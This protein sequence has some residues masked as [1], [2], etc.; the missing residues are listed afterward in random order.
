MVTR[1]KEGSKIRCFVVLRPTIAPKYDVTRLHVTHSLSSSSHWTRI[2]KSGRITSRRY[3]KK[4]GAGGHNKDRDIVTL[5]DALRTTVLRTTVL[6]ATYYCTTYY[7]TTCYV[8][9][10]YVLRTTYYVLC[11]FIY[12]MGVCDR[13]KKCCTER[14][15]TYCSGIPA[16]WPK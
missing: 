13:T 14:C 3:D 8:L 11:I 15:F 10:Y 2:S 4:T 5:F 1:G 6:R 9:L 12:H 7:C 16:T